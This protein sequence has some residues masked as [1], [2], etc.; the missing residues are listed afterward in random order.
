VSRLTKC[1][2]GNARNTKN[3]P[4]N[5]PKNALFNIVPGTINYT[6]YA[7]IQTYRIKASNLSNYFYFPHVTKQDY[8]HAFNNICNNALKDPKLTPILAARIYYVKEEA[9]RKLVF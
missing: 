1:P 3:T 7:T 8:D 5:A 4:K 2:I 9:L 6:L